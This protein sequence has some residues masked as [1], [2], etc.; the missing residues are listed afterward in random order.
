M[1]AGK[2]IRKAVFCVDNVH[3]S[4]SENDIRSFV[5]G[6]S[7]QVVSYFAVK[8]R[9]RR[10]ETG[11]TE[12]RKAFRF[13]VVAEDRDRLLDDTKWPES[14]MISEWYTMST[15]P[16]GDRQRTSQQSTQGIQLWRQINIDV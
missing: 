12:D 3:P 9:R 2:L 13:C 8:P 1:A 11:L 15:L 7:V 10:N 14:V 5:A 6:L 16:I 4:V